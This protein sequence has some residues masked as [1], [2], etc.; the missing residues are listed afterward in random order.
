MLRRPMLSSMLPLSSTII[1]NTFS[2][3]TAWPIKVKFNVMPPEQGGRTE[4]DI[5][6]SGHIAKMAARPIYGKIL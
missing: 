3:E 6:V 1:S 5:N 4:V 2:S